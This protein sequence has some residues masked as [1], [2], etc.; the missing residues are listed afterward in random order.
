MRTKG[1]NKSK[2]VILLIREGG[3]GGVG[4]GGEGPTGALCTGF[5]LV[6]LK[7]QEMFYDIFKKMN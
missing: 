1:E 2:C 4:T 7:Q 5:T 3:G 6:V